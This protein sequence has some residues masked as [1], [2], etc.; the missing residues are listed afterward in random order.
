LLELTVYP[1]AENVQPSKIDSVGDNWLSR[2]LSVVLLMAVAINEMFVV[3][4]AATKLA[5]TSQFVPPGP[6]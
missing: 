1:V 2:V 4:V 5:P 6:L 3:L